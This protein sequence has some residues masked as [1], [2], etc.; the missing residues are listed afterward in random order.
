MN[1]VF[2]GDDVNGLVD[3]NI[4]TK[5]SPIPINGQEPY[6]YSFIAD[7]TVQ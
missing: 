2:S 1:I 3:S 7:F 4:V 6:I 5:V